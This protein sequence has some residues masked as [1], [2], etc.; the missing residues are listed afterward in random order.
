MANEH[1]PDKPATENGSL[2]DFGKKV[3]TMLNKSKP[4]TQKEVIAAAR[5]L[6]KKK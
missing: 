5:E 3:G 4:M 6:K 2:N 1:T